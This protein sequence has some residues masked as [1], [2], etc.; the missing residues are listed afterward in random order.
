MFKPLAI[1]TIVITS[2]LCLWGQASVDNSFT[3]GMLNGRG[4]QTLPT[5]IK[6]MYIAG[7]RDGMTLMTS[8]LTTGSEAATNVVN[9]IWF[10][11]FSGPDYLKE[12]DKLY[13]DGENV[14]IPVAMAISY[15]SVKLHGQTTKVELEAR[16]MR[17][18]KVVMDFK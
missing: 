16:L 12:L 3:A 9:E 2:Q 1:A 11:G 14:R 18:R 17:I 6:Q 13:A 7:I 5:T 10:K 8:E 15:C 4:W